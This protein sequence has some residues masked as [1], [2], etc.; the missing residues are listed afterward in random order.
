MSELDERIGAVVLRRRETLGISQSALS[1]D[2]MRRGIS[3]AH[4]TWVSRVEAGQQ[5]LRLTDAPVVAEALGCSIEDLLDDS[6]ARE[7]PD[8]VRYGIEMSIKALTNLMEKL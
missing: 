2:L 4:Q 8:L 5:P 6:G 3:R 1:K 7:D